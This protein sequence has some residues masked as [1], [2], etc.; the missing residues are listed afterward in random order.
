[1]A[2]NLRILLDTNILIPLHDSLVV[3]RP[4]LAHVIQ[5]A[6]GRHQ[7]LFHPA[8]RRDI[9][10][11]TDVAR[12][13][14]TLQRLV[15]YT[16]LP[17][18]PPCPWTRVGMSENDKCDNAILYALSRDAAHALI[19]EDRRL[20]TKAALRGLTNRVYFIQT[21]EDWLQRLHEPEEI[22]VPNVVDVELNELT[23]LL[24]GEFFD[25]LRASYTPFD[26]WF[27]RKAREG[28]HAWVYR[29]N[30]EEQLS[31]LCVYDIQEDEEVT[32]DG[33]ILPRRALKLCTFK[34]AG[35]VRGR[36]IGELF[37]KASFKYATANA[38]ENIFIDVSEQTHPELILLLKDFGFSKKGVHNDDAVFV[39]EHPLE[40]P[41]ID[42][43]ESDNFAYTRKYYPHFRDDIDI[44]KFI[45]PIRPEYHRILFTDYAS[46]ILD[47]PEGHAEHVG[48]AIKLAYLSNSPSGRIRRGDIVL[49]YRTHDE[50]AITTIGV[51]EEFE[52]IASADE[53]AS[54]VSRRTVYSEQGIVAMAEA[55][56]QQRHG[57]VRVMLFRTIEHLP[58][59]VPR[60]VLLR[61]RVP[62]KI[63]S[64]RN[65]ND[66]TFSR[67][68]DASGR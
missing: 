25:S 5:L 18:G 61:L 66:D 58:S 60:S 35:Q 45:I 10:R 12:R 16:E 14:R 31:A 33:F 41:Q 36:K 19:T 56:A 54:L 34:V 59:P 3:L 46:N 50:K 47:T 17:E 23:P 63:I 13:N 51:V 57:G 6:Q 62:G 11:D 44:A 24:P 20:H 39:K 38:C 55:A 7:F 65:I 26:T 53:I 29:H 4:N 67:I 15:Q 1:M 48:N 40:A 42:F 49:F 37:L 52:T 30:D 9:Q 22:E 27:K 21:A 32:D 2:L 43:E 68:L 64:T 8:S 28:R